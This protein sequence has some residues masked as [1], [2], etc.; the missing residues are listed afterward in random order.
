M[1]LKQKKP[2]ASG[3]LFVLFAFE[4]GT[5]ERSVFSGF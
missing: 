3:F 5:N 4:F 1:N 2:D